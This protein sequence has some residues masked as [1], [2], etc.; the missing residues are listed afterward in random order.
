MI[1]EIS[2]ELKIDMQKNNKLGPIRDIVMS[3][4]SFSFE[5]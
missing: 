3:N 2:K 1:D 4:R 5:K